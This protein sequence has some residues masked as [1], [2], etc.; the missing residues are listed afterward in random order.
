MVIDKEVEGLL[1]SLVKKGYA[2]VKTIG[3]KK[4]YGLTNKGKG[5]ALKMKAEVENSGGNPKN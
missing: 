3:N 1:D 5:E 2:K 4:F